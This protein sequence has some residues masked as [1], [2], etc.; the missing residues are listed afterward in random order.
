[1]PEV[2]LLFRPRH[3]AGRSAHDGAA[4][5]LASVLPERL[6]RALEYSRFEHLG[7]WDAAFVEVGC[8]QVL[9]SKL[10]DLGDVG[11]SHQPNLPA[12]REGN[13]GAFELEAQADIA[14][15]RPENRDQDLVRPRDRW[16]DV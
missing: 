11:H 4:A 6:P 8:E 12:V 3:H 2:G 5:R 1:M 14:L 7:L 13:F 16:G 9:A 10:L 15:Q